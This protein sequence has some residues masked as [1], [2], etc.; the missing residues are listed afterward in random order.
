[1]TWYLSPGGLPFAAT[2]KKPPAGATHSATEGAPRWTLLPGTGLRESWVGR[3]YVPRFPV[4]LCPDWALP[5][6]CES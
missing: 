1:M 2:A 6:A 4:D 3:D 5:E